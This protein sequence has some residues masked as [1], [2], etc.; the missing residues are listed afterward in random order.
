MKRKDGIKTF[1]ALDRNKW[2]KWLEINHMIEEKVWLIMYHKNSAVQS[3]YYDEAVEEALCF[4]W[5]DSKPNKRDNESFYQ[6]FSKRNPKSNW[7]KLN[8]TR[9][10]KLIKDG[11]MT[12]AGLEMIELAKR[13]GTWT[14][15][16]D[17]ENLI[18]PKD[19]KNEFDEY[20]NAASNFNTFPSSAKKA[21]LEWIKTAK[22]NETRL[23]RIKQTALLADKNI[24]AN[25]YRAS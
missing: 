5:I 14:F 16:D 18:I 12:K 17:V 25:E 8:K 2:R 23:K 11:R 22:R 3:V 19:L 7:S 4:G 13:T 21:I 15:L 9:V 1:H 10:E 24:R 20:K 6:F